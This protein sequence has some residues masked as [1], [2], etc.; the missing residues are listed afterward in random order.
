M[1]TKLTKSDRIE[2]RVSQKI[3]ALIE[4]AAQ[5]KGLSVSAFATAILVE[6]AKEVIEESSRIQLSNRD[7]EIFL[8]ALDKGPNKALLKAAKMFKSHHEN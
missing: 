4:R 7:Q 3:K 2:V 5:E 6:S 8:K 1:K